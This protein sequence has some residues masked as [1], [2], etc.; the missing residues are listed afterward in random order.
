M[1]RPTYPL[2]VSI[3]KDQ[4]SDAWLCWDGEVISLRPLVLSDVAELTTLVR[5]NRAFLG[6]WEPA[7]DDSYFTQEAQEAEVRLL[8]EA[9]ESGMKEPFV[10]EDDGAFA[11]RITLNNIVRGPFQSSSVG[12]WVDGERGGRGIATAALGA[13]VRLSFDE[14]GLHRLEAGTLVHNVRSQRVLAANGFQQFG[15]APRYL[16]IDGEWQ[17]HLLFQLVHDEGP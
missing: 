6:P 4:P 8:L 12:Y 5:R 13:L 10:I 1:S 16:C 9:R 3:P 14:L 17:D 11:G 15:M 7:R 2:G